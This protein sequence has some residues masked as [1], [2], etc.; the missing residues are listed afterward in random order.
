MRT[1]VPTEYADF[2][3]GTSWHIVLA[4]YIIATLS[5]MSGAITVAAFQYVRGDH[6]AQWR[7]AII[8]A[9]AVVGAAIGILTLASSA[10][11]ELPWH[12]S[13]YHLVFASFLSGVV[14]SAALLATNMGLM[15]I[16][17]RMGVEVQVILRKPKD[18]KDESVD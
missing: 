15:L 2:L 7:A 8:A 5:G 16:M 9:Y 11:F 18:I 14:G 6:V 10:V 13:I 3:E 17:K 4:S 12:G 1:D